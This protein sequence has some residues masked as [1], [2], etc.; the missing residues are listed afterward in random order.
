M[1]TIIRDDNI[2]TYQYLPVGFKIYHGSHKRT[3]SGIEPWGGERDAQNTYINKNHF[4][5]QHGWFSNP[6]IAGHYSNRLGMIGAQ[7][8]EL[9]IIGSELCGTKCIF[10]Y[11][12]N[13]PMK[14]IYMN[15]IFNLILIISWL[16]LKKQIKIIKNIN[17][18]YKFN[19]K[20]Y[21]NKIF[22]IFTSIDPKLNIY[23]IIT[24]YIYKKGKYRKDIFLTLRNIYNI[25]IKPKYEV[26]LIRFSRM[27]IDNNIAKYFKTNMPFSL[28]NG[29]GADEIDTNDSNVPFVK[30]H[31]E[32]V[33]FDTR[34]YI[35]RDL[36]NPIDWQHSVALNPT[37]QKQYIHSLFTQLQSYKSKNYNY[38]AGDLLD[39]SVW[40]V[41]HAEDYIK[42]SANNLPEEL[43]RI[44]V[45]LSFLHYTFVMNISENKIFEYKKIENH[46][47]IPE[48]FIDLPLAC[49]KF[50]V[51]FDLF[52]QY[53]NILLQYKDENIYSNIQTNITISNEYKTILTI[54]RYSYIGSHIGFGENST[55]EIINSIINNP[56]FKYQAINHYKQ[57]FNI[58]SIYFPFISN[59][60]IKYNAKIYKKNIKNIPY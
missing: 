54:V 39:K 55:F 24:D 3:R 8:T 11:T 2:F 19:V 17:E 57:N 12:I 4:G 20:G 50:N 27:A 48:N 59:H 6:S 21:V 1:E 41:L 43:K 30:F 5:E 51:D 25:L 38:Y 49:Q 36:A 26:K 14:L 60:P 15:D 44:A 46:K 58:K 34:K 37:F 32:K 56:A 18:A 13:E 10:C 9:D 35:S 47:I 42:K 53:V 33:L 29:F 7:N 40:A 16:Q 23:D 52:S 22:E 45:F 28:Y 31:E